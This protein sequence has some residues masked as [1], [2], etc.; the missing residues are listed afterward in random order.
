MTL[1]VEQILTIRFSDTDAMGVVWHGNYIKF[2]EDGREAFGEKFDLKYLDVY[3]RGYFTP[4]VRMEVDHKAPIYYGDTVKLITTFIPHR[5]AKMIFE[6]KIVNT[7]SNTIVA[8]GK[9]IQVF[10]HAGNRTL[11]L[12]NP[13]FYETWKT[14]YLA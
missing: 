10:M 11:E 7:T 12:N 1:Q 3:D 9:S 14:Q 5:A 13:A 4:I 2:F 8:K 6:Y